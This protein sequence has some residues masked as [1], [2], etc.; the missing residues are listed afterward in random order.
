ME[1]PTDSGARV[2]STRVQAGQTT[3]ASKSSPAP[4]PPSAVPDKKAKMP[5]YD[6]S[7]GSLTEEEQMELPER[8]PKPRD[9]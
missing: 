9:E 4:A 2:K 1:Q 6:F 5:K 8:T 3:K 7:L